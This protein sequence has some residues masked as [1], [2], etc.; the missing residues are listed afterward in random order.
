M[1]QQNVRKLRCLWNCDTLE[2]FTLVN[3]PQILTSTCMIQKYTFGLPDY[4]QK[5]AKIRAQ[6]GSLVRAFCLVCL[7]YWIIEF[8]LYIYLLLIGQMGCMFWLNNFKNMPL[9]MKKLFLKHYR[10]SVFI[11]SWRSFKV[12][13]SNPVHD[14]RNWK[15]AEGWDNDA[16]LEKGNPL[17]WR[18]QYRS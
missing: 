16:E 13:Y 7:L 5:D 14:P 12:K 4:N 11:F 1:D 9:F 6:H 18:L 3:E 17:T 15:S 10:N 2:K 8:V